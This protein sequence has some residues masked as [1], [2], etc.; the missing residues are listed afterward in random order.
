M[1]DLRW[2]IRRLGAM[3]AGEL[4]W[5]VQQKGLGLAE[6][7]RFR[8]K[9]AVTSEIFHK[10]RLSHEIPGLQGGSTE[11][12]LLRTELLFLNF[13]NTDYSVNDTIKLPPP[14]RYED[15]RTRWHAGFQTDNDWPLVPSGRLDYRGMDAV[16]DART[17]WELN[18]HFQFALLAK[19]YFI[20]RDTA[21][22]D[23]LAALFGD[24]NEKNPFLWGISWVSA[25]EIAERTLNW[26]LTLAFLRA[27]GKAPRGLERALETG[28]INMADYL[29]HHY[30]RYSSANNHLII[31][32]TAV[33]H[34]GVL[35]G[36][37][38]WVDCAARILDRELFLQNYGDG[39]N[40]EEALFYQIFMMEAYALDLRLLRK[41]G[42][43]EEMTARWIPL[44]QRMTRYV[45]DCIGKYGEVAEFGDNDG[46]KLVDLGSGGDR[47]VNLLQ[48]MACLLPERTVDMDPADREM[49]RSPEENVR[50]LFMERELAE[51]DQ[52]PKYTPTG[53]VDYAE[54]GNA[55]LRSSD[56][57]VL[58]GI[59]HAPLGYG[60]LC[61]HGHADALSF[62]AFVRGARFL[63]DPGTCIYHTDEAARN[64]F[65]AT[66]N[67]NTVCIGDR[68][69]SE[70]LGAFLWGR[71]AGC[72]LLRA[73]LS[74][75]RD[76]IEAEQDGY[77]PVMHRRCFRF[78]RENKVLT[79]EDSVGGAGDAV[80]R[81]L[82]APQTILE[83]TETGV[84]R[85]VSGKTGELL[86]SVEFRQGFERAV[87]EE[88]EY[89]EEYGKREK[90]VGL[91]AVITG[92]PAVTVIRFGG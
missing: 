81:L 88:R 40:K 24:W 59:D 20:T 53:S 52:K 1:A 71:K 35:T 22:L 73:E 75:E 49:G 43:K 79:I 42:L 8:R 16:G 64:A 62:I 19:D 91:A 83:E 65:R 92:D 12:E 37:T 54:G 34:A 67:H 77:A 55:M 4:L 30:S 48:L 74:G 13:H 68:D 3:S 66:R 38:K 25:I 45:R 2:Y 44:L 50:W 60:A 85:C 70:M 69:Q 15:Y 33:L 31:E 51:A 36:N 29:F 41:N 47:Y 72:R 28:I 58:I 56:G 84:Y 57:E 5:R 61:A 82:F 86:G 18:K 10:K 7:R 17:N 90:T 46:G 87:P 14:Y 26:C 9:C 21:R 32:I 23:E 39:V 89:S 63:C 76:I 27:A 80:F 78:D 11:E 6:A